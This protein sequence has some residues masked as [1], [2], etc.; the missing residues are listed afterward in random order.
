MISRR[1]FLNSVLGGMAAGAGLASSPLSLRFPTADAATPNKTFIYVDNAG[2]MDGIHWLP[3]YTDP[4]YQA[5]RPTIH[6]DPPNSSG[7][8]C[9]ALAGSSDFGLNPNLGPLIDIWEAGQMAMFPAAGF[10]EGTGSHFDSQRFLAHGEAVKEGQGIFNRYLD[11]NPGDI[12]LRALNLTGRSQRALSGPTPVPT[13]RNVRDFKLDA[14]H[15]QNVDLMYDPNFQTVIQSHEQLHRQ[16]SNL[17]ETLDQLGSLPDDYTPEGGGAYQPVNNV[18]RYHQGFAVAAQ[19]IK[20]GIRP[21]VMVMSASGDFDT[22]SDSF[23]QR[24]TDTLRSFAN[25][26]RT[27]YDDLGPTLMRDVVVVVGSEF[28]RTINENR[29]FGTDHGRGNNWIAI[30]GNV[31]GGLYGDYPGLESNANGNS[32][33]SMAFRVNVKDIFGQILVNHLGAI[34][35]TS[36]FPGHSFTTDSNLFFMNVSS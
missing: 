10:P 14:E 3:P 24:G 18:G 30:G 35:V 11:T 8:P 1:F 26:M 23:R 36:V 5:Q 13:I 21:E 16:A 7:R 19:L 15:L 33:R 31:Q 20:A 12:G 2:G 22:H 32:R 27:F 9:L 29:S 4:F 28:G 25:N 34:D 6:F 17:I